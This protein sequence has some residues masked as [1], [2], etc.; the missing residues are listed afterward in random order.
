MEPSQ[1][2]SDKM[3]AWWTNFTA[4]TKVADQIARKYAYLKMYNL[5]GLEG[6]RELVLLFVDENRENDSHNS[7]IMV[8]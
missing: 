1:T 3:G 8:P 5:H 6:S 4:R 7:P 2:W